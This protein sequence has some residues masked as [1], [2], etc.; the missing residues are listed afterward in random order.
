MTTATAML[1]GHSSENKYQ[2]QS[3]ELFLNL[4]IFVNRN[5]LNTLYILKHYGDSCVYTLLQI[6]A[7][8]SCMLG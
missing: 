1:S 7:R 3:K 6:I 8:L 4:A 5:L 2:S